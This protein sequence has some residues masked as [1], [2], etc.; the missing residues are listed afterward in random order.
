LLAL[1]QDELPHVLDDAAGTLKHPQRPPVLDVIEHGQVA[2]DQRL[3]TALTPA[4]VVEAAVC[5]PLVVV[6]VLLTGPRVREDE[7]VGALARGADAVL[8]AAAVAVMQLAATDRLPRLQR[9]FR[10]RA[11]VGG[12]PG[13]LMVVKDCLPLLIREREGVAGPRL[14][15]DRRPGEPGIVAELLP[16]DRCAQEHFR[17]LQRQPPSGA[18]LA[19][20]GLV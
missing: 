13:A 12:R 19:S 4:G 9:P 20:Q 15:Q 10:A 8:A 14:P 17:E 3:V 5:C 11:G 16:G 1:V 7:N 2:A 6:A 18:V